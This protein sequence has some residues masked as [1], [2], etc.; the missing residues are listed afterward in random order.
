MKILQLLILL[1]CL[2]ITLSTS[3]FRFIDEISP[4]EK[5][6]KKA[7]NNYKSKTKYISLSSY[8]KTLG[9]TNK[10][11][12]KFIRKLL[13]ENSLSELGNCL[14]QMASYLV[15]I[16]FGIAFLLSKYTTYQNSMLCICSSMFAYASIYSIICA[17]YRYTS[18]ARG[19]K[20]NI[21]TSKKIELTHNSFPITHRDSANKILI[22]SR[23]NKAEHS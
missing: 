2:S 15:M 4:K 19:E 20:Q 23:F 21:T 13:L 5:V 10:N 17:I 14:K 6:C 12:Q 22:I 3:S 18:Q 1:I 8:V 7:L 9:E 16:G 11:K